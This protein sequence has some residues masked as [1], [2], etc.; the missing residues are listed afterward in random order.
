[1]TRRALV[2][3]VALASALP[4]LAQQRAL[5]VDDLFALKNVG[6]P[7]LSPDGQWVAYTV[8][9]LDAKDDQSDTDIYLAPFAGGEPLRLTGSKKPETSP[10]FS[11]DGKWI[12]FLSA[13]EGKKTQV[14]LL[15]LQG[16]EATRLTDFKASVSALEWSPDGERLAL[17]IADVDPDDPDNAS[18]EADRPRAAKPI[19]VRRLQSKRDGQGY[20]RELRRHVHLF[21]VK[22]KSSVQ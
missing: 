21:D 3:L 2:S 15:P 20:L 8:Q 14:W 10:R 7:R 18:G 16:G 5:R 1:M 13:R 17:V 11:P 22:A 6:D 9:S 4:A 12:A 19:V